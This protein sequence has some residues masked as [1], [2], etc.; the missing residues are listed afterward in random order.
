LTH[1]LGGVDREQPISFL[2]QGALTPFGT[3]DAVSNA[4]FA[5]LHR[6]EIISLLAGLTDELSG[7]LLTIGRAELARYQ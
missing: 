5:S 7:A 1:D 4:L 6:V 2:A 3:F